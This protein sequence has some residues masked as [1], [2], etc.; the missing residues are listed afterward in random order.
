M[1]PREVIPSDWT[2]RLAGGPITLGLDIGTTEKQTSNPS[3][4]TVTEKWN[5]LYVERL[6]TAWKTKDEAIT[7]AILE[8]VINDLIAS[9]RRW[10]AG[11]VDAS[12]ETLFAQ[13][14]RKLFMSKVRLMLIKGG[15]KLKHGLQEY[16]A[17]TL[18][19]GLYCNAYADGI[20][21]IPAD[22]WI[23]DDRR[24]VKKTGARFECDLG[25][26]G[27]HGDTFDSGKHA[28]WAHIAKSSQ[29]G[30]QACDISGTSRRDD[31]DDDGLSKYRSSTTNR[32]QNAC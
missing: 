31:D 23:K 29:V 9:G 11:S 8:I 6:V 30:A 27:E 14:L 12:N 1:I 10:K 20:I 13:R 3:S 28:Y 4:I 22:Q 32:T 17:K 21:A 26:N 7:T 19:G 15:N 2:V 5:G 24:L 25:K 18:M 16:D